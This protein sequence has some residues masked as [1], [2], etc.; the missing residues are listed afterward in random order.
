MSEEINLNQ[1]NQLFESTTYRLQATFPEGFDKG[2]K[3]PTWGTQFTCNTPSVASGVEAGGPHAR[4]WV[5]GTAE[6]WGDVI[7]ELIQEIVYR[8]APEVVR[9][10]KDKIGIEIA[11]DQLWRRIIFSIGKSSNWYGH[12]EPFKANRREA[13]RR[14]DA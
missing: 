13:A 10:S 1:L 7:S 5:E 11:C 14:S 6:A 9:L 8:S 3:E 4:A 12:D 2:V